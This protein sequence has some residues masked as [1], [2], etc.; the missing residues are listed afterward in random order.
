MQKSDGE[1]CA[2]EEEPVAVGEKERTARAAPRSALTSSPQ[3][4][5]HFAFVSSRQTTISPDV[6]ITTFA[7][8]IV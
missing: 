8:C 3:R 5:S 2:V 4:P 7:A 1:V 6:C